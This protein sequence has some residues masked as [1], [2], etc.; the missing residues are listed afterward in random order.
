MCGG[1]SSQTVGQSWQHKAR[2]HCS[3]I[4]LWQRGFKCLVVDVDEV[5]MSVWG[6]F[7]AWQV[8]MEAYSGL[9]ALKCQVSLKGWQQGKMAE[10]CMISKQP[11]DQRG[12]TCS[13][14]ATHSL[15]PVHD[16]RLSWNFV[17]LF[18]SSLASVK[19]HLKNYIFFLYFSLY[20]FHWVKTKPLDTNTSIPKSKGAERRIIWYHL[21]II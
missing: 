20:F 5:D 16:T 21:P 17:I 18:T 7:A 13:H 15:S 19:T 4:I 3:V 6:S 12:R 2:T 9:T 11:F 14:Q 8:Y 1:H 10:G